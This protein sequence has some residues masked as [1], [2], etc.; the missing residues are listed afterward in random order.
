MKHVLYKMLLHIT[1][2][3]FIAFKKEPKTLVEKC[4]SFTLLKLMDTWIFQL[5]LLLI[6]IELL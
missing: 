3:L 6:C 2:H 1:K 5:I 4:T